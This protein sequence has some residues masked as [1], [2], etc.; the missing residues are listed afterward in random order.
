MQSAAKC[1]ILVTFYCNKYAGPDDYFEKKMLEKKMKREHPSHIN[2]EME[3]DY[4]PIKKP[5]SSSVVKQAGRTS[6][7]VM[8]KPVGLDD[9]NIDFDSQPK[10]SL[11]SFN[12]FNSLNSTKKLTNGTSNL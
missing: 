6:I 7:N 12:S 8:K 11:G 10:S 2:L 9:I 1:P 5:G 4:R 3:D